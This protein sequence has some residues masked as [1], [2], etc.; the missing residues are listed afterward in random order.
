MIDAS[1]SCL[2]T[3]GALPLDSPYATLWTKRPGSDHR[4]DATLQLVMAVGWLSKAAAPAAISAAAQ[5]CELLLHDQSTPQ[6]SSPP[7]FQHEPDAK[8]TMAA[9]PK[10]K[11]PVPKS[12]G[13]S[14]C[15]AMLPREAIAPAVTGLKSQRSYALPPPPGLYLRL[16]ARRAVH[17]LGNDSARKPWCFRGPS[18]GGFNWDRWPS[19]AGFRPTISRAN[20]RSGSA[21]VC[22]ACRP[23][24]RGDI[25]GDGVRCLQRP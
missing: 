6:L 8:A 15:I 18:R 23:Q 22:Q 5:A 25:Q 12:N 9:I 21:G 24:D 1:T 4:D 2:T 17:K 11:S 19:T 10:S 13:N 16:G 20:A 14:I 7:M 3:A